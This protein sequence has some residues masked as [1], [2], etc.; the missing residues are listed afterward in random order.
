[1]PGPIATL[2]FI[3][4]EYERGALLMHLWATAKRVLI[5][6]AIGMSLGVILGTAM[7]MSQRIDQLL[8]GWL[9]AGL[10]IPRI[11]LFVMAYI[12]L[13]LSDAA[14]IGALVVTVI[15]GVVVQIREGTRALDQGLI[16]MAHAYRRSPPRIWR[17]VILPQLMPYV[18]GTGRASLSLAWKMVVLAELLGR[19]SGVGYQISFYFQMFNM[20]GILAYGVTMMVLLAIIDLGLLGALQRRAFRW[21][22]PAKAR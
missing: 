6:F 20:L 13:G 3:A 14:A 9:I 21:R 7:G 16:E 4:R 19:T 10:T 15:P 11:I 22:A 1:M 2:E 5:A 17:S 12:L 18:I 8:E